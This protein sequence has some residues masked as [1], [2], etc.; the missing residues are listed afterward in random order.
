VKSFRSIR[1]DVPEKLEAAILRA[2]SRRRDDR[3]PTAMDFMEAIIAMRRSLPY[4]V[5]HGEPL[6]NR[7]D[8]PVDRNSNTMDLGDVLL[9]SKVETPLAFENEGPRGARRRSRRRIALGLW[10]SIAL[11]V[12]VAATL[13][14]NMKSGEPSTPDRIVQADPPKAEKVGGAAATVKVVVERRPAQAEVTVA[15]RVVPVDGLELPRGEAELELVIRADGYVTQ[16]TVLVPDKDVKLTVAL[17]PQPAPKPQVKKPGGP[18]GAAKAGDAGK[19]PAGGQTAGGGKE[20]VPAA[21][22]TPGT[23]KPKGLDTPMDNPF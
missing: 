4:E 2:L 12:A 8:R 10:G 17:E 3:W 7:D 13:F 20:V 15:G 23:D 18:K 14:F 19:K 6:V 9:Q 1:P 16:R 5:L 11:V 22:K 21:A